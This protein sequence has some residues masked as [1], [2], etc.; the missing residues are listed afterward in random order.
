MQTQSPGLSWNHSDGTHHC[1]CEECKKNKLNFLRFCSPSSKTVL[2]ENWIRR[3]NAS[4]ETAF[5]FDKG[6]GMRKFEDFI[7]VYMTLGRPRM[8]EN[9]VG[10]TNSYVE[11]KVIKSPNR[12]FPK[13]YNQQRNEFSR[14][15]A[16]QKQLWSRK[17]FRY[18]INRTTNRV[19]L[20]S[21][22]AAL[23][24]LRPLI[25]NQNALIS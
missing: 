4:N 12:K 11:W 15:W 25:S 21:K 9:T 7:A 1:N 2:T 24:Q 18:Q 5:T 3:T 20:S 6:R 23:N 17:S 13:R 14:F 10:S 19:F 8:F 16:R 22:E